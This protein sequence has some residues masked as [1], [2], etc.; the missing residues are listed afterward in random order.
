MTAI[1]ECRETPGG[2]TLRTVGMRT[3]GRGEGS[4]CTNSIGSMRA[5]HGG[6]VCNDG[7]LAQVSM[8]RFSFVLGAL[9]LGNVPI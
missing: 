5:T 6:H 3:G 4:P 8:H 9:E 2:S 7:A 1:F